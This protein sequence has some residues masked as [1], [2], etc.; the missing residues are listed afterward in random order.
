MKIGIFYFSHHHLSDAQQII[1]IPVAQVVY[2]R[3]EIVEG[4]D[5]SA[6]LARAKPLS[7]DEWV[8]NTHPLP[9]KP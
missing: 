4:N 6:A 5:L 7:K 3:V 1:T 2:V 9:E 8:M